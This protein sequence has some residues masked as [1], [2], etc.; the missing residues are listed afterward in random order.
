MLCASHS[1]R[2]HFNFM[3]AP[4]PSD[5]RLEADKG[6]KRRR[7][8][9]K[10]KKEKEDQV[11]GEAKEEQTSTTEGE[12]QQVS[13]GVVDPELGPPTDQDLSFVA[14][15]GYVSHILR[16][17][18]RDWNQL[19]AVECVVYNFVEKRM[20]QRI[21]SGIAFRKLTESTKV[22]R[23]FTNKPKKKAY[24]VPSYPPLVPTAQPPPPDLPPPRRLQRAE[25][26][27]GLRTGRVVLILERCGDGFNQQALLRTADCLGI[28]HVWLV[29]PPGRKI[30]NS[31][32]LNRNVT[33][34]SHDWLTI[35]HF[36]TTR[37]C[38]EALRAE[39]REIWVTDLS[40]DAICLTD[41]DPHIKKE[42]EISLKDKKIGLVAGQEGDGATAE[43]KEAADRRIYLPMCGFAD[44]FNVSVAMALVLQKL[45][46]L[47]PEARGDLP[48]EEKHAL[49]IKWYTLLAKDVE[50]NRALFAQYIN[51]PP[52]PLD[53]LRSY[54]YNVGFKHG[55]NIHKRNK[56]T[57]TA[58]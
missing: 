9:R 57:T 47:C 21:M 4:T 53:D 2:S 20:E 29:N 37:E 25:R 5:E 7:E 54:E 42:L 31:Q 6:V 49:R 38:I 45:L 3:D 40:P 8:K 52:P 23:E 30:K 16:A 58:E 22:W 24:S 11:K 1:N 32:C 35:R 27:L 46:S 12:E 56:N 17:N 50:S 43:I 10:K 28:Q 18:T 48:E 15:I 19:K 13:R 26:I 41:D 14:N 44:S 33:K 39:G 51:F 34:G 36:D 55:G